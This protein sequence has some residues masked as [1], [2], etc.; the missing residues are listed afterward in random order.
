MVKEKIKQKEKVSSKKPARKKADNNEITFKFSMKMDDN[1]LSGEGSFK[2]AKEMSDEQREKIKNNIRMIQKM[3]MVPNPHMRREH[4][5]MN[6][7]VDKVDIHALFDIF[8]DSMA[9][10]KRYI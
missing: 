6:S 2:P 9:Q 10:D 4:M 7:N 5:G 1:G 3:L 8:N